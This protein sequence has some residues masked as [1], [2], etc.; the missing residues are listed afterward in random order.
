[1]DIRHT[2]RSFQTLQDREHRGYE[3][4]AGALVQ[5]APSRFEGG[6]EEEIT[7]VDTAIVRLLP[8]K[9]AGDVGHIMGIQEPKRKTKGGKPDWKSAVREEIP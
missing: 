3:L 5:S 1:M 7:M 4:R 9:R 6:I 2:S 8:L